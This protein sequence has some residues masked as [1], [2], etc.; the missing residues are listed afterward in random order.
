MADPGETIVEVARVL[1]PGG[2]FAI[3][4]RVGDDDMPAWMDPDVY[5]IPHIADI[6]TMLDAAGFVD[7]EHH[8][9]PDV[10]AY[11]HWFVGRAPGALVR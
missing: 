8:G 2:R 10:S 7:V 11:T 3:A 4:C 5:R 6:E 1:R 9:W